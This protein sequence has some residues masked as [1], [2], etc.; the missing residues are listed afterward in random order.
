[1]LLQILWPDGKFFLKLEITGGGLDEMVSKCFQATPRAAKTKSSQAGLFEMHL[2][3]AR[4]A[5][6]IRNVLFR[7]LLSSFSN[8]FIQLFSVF[9]F[10]GKGGSGGG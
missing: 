9:C 2:E 5:S 10:F 4:R 6:Y 8:S 1:V 3:A 7:K